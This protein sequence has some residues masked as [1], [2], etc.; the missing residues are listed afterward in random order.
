MAQRREP[1]RLVLDDD[2]A[3]GMERAAMNADRLSGRLRYLADAV[4]ILGPMRRCACL[5]CRFRR[6]FRW[7]R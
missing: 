2:F 5:S 7:R 4:A 3:A 1:A 6:P